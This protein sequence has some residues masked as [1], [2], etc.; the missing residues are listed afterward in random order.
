MGA[1]I[2]QTTYTTKTDALLRGIGVIEYPAADRLLAQDTALARYS[3]D[4]AKLPT[5]DFPGDGGNYYVAYGQETNIL[6]STQDATVDLTSSGADS[7]LGVSFTL[8]YRMEVHAVRFLLKR[9]DTGALAGTVACEIRLPGTN[10]PSTIVAQTS[11]SLDLAA[12]TAAIPLGYESGKTEFRFTSPT[13]LDAGTY[14]AVL[15]PSGYTYVNTVTEV[16]LGVDQSSVTNT[17][18]TFD[19]TSTWTAFGTDSAGIVEVIASFPEWQYRWSYIKGADIPAPTISADEV[20][21]PLEDEDFDL[22]NVQETEYIYFP[23]NAPTSSETVRL[24]YAAKYSFDGV[25]IATDVPNAHFE[26]VCQ[27]TAHYIC[28]SLAARYGQNVDSGHSFDLSDKRGQSDIYASRA[29]GFLTAYAAMT[30]I[31]LAEEGSDTAAVPAMTIGDM[32]RE[33][34]SP[35]QPLFHS[36]RKR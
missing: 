10:V 24:S 20:P 32:D 16:A 1:T 33:T 19:G 7:E 8:P 28:I 6:N 21:R 31:V 30:G 26:A 23:N 17:L 27:L 2:L 3:Q 36:R 5:I 25:P 9:I 34:Y 29:K 18:F 13:P 12:A 35:R 11:G 4:F 22:V 14:Y 15:V